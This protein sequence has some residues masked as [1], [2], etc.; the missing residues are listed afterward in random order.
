MVASPS[1]TP[2]S[3]LVLYVFGGIALLT[4]AL[5]LDAMF[6]GAPGDRKSPLLV[7]CAASLKKAMTAVAADYQRETGAEVELTFG[8]SQTLLANI[9]VTSR[10][11]LFLPA[12]D[13]YLVPARAKNLVAST[14]PLA[15][16]TAV[17]AVQH[18]NPKGLH[19]LAD[20][21]VSSATLSQADPDAAAIGK[22]VR[23]ATAAS[24]LWLVISNHVT[25]FKPTVTDSAND[26]KLG[27][28]DAAIVWDSMQGQYAGLEFVRAPEL[29][30]VKAKIAIAVLNCSAQRQVAEKFA[31]YVATPEKGLRQFEA[32]GFQVSATPR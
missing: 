9:A 2:R 17:L 8:G 7:H 15:E 6:R 25:V 3:K 1:A 32:N 29:A 21:R 27:A 30:P 20:L 5:G 10:G 13:S 19:T 31:R 24:G 11:D 16:Q 14:V 4:L 26:V 18:G 22:L 12:D 28:V 23:D